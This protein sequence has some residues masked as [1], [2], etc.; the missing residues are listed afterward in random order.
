[1]GLR[2][3]MLTTF[4]PPWSFGGDAIGVERLAKG[5]VRR[6]HEVTV[7]HDRDAWQTLAPGREPAAAPPPLPGL[8]V[9]SLRARHGFA[10]NLLTHQFGRPI[11]HGRR[12]AGLLRDGSFDV[13][14]F[15]NVSLLGGP[16]LLK[17]GRGVKLLMAHDHWL[18]CPTHVLWRHA[19]ELCDRR[20]CL[21]CVVKHGRPP[22][23]W[24]YSG[25]LERELRH[26]D[27]FIAM[28]EFS[29]AKHREFGFRR[30]MEVLPY[31]LPD[32]E[33]PQQATAGATS[34]SGESPEFAGPS[35]HPRPYFLFVGRLERIKGLDDVVP[36]FADA[37]SSACGLAAD[38]VVAGDGEHGA[39][40]RD[41]ARGSPRV[42][43]LGR[44]A[45]DELAPWYRHALALI[46]PSLCFETFGIVLIEAFRQRLPVVA[47]RLGPFPEIVERARAGEL[48]ATREELLGALRRLQD[49]A[50]LRA[51]LGAAGS[52]AWRE[53]WSESAVVPRY[54]DLVRRVAER[55]G[56]EDVVAK[57]A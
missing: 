45:V 50:P 18:V 40:L 53:H 35:P 30:E 12:I 3:A 38:L 22:Q 55:K 29:R 26:V 7:V 56:R 9:V 2:V 44:V 5:L 21:K 6:G 24:R 57:L 31:F 42:R 49:D 36:L 43:F 33:E 8:D 20:E 39:V 4:Y 17:Y 34:V 11:V 54:L 19:R 32:H 41:L 37:A 13:V 27:A 52:A 23:L 1:M 10:S 28:S 48:F 25:L 14:Q 15:H 16:G 47:R 46:V 51:R